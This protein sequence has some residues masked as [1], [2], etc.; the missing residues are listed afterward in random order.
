MEFR[1]LFLSLPLFVFLFAQQGL[2]LCTRAR[3]LA[4]RIYLSRAH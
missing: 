1:D 2:K 4:A 3:N